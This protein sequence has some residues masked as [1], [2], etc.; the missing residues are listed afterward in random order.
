MS[1]TLSSTEKANGRRLP[2]Q[3]SE[4]LGRFEESILLAA[5]SLGP[6]V[7]A[8]SIKNL[9]DARIGKR[10]I[11]TVLTTLDRLE[12]KGLVEADTEETPSARRGGRKRRF[13]RVTSDGRDSAQRS[14]QLTNDLAI[15]AGLEVRAA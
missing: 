4:L 8:A 6:D 13:Y 15:A 2:P 7:T 12:E 14:F 9:I 10:A 1:F 3:R 5:L 11:S